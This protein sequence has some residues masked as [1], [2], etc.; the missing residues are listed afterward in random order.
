MEYA[1][2]LIIH[3]LLAIII[4]GGIL[5]GRMAVIP[6]A[7]RTNNPEFAYNFENAFSRGA[8]AALTIQFLVGFR[9]GMLQL[10]MAD[11]FTFE[12]SMSITL[13]AKLALFVVLFAWTI[14]GKR[15]FV[16]NA[17]TSDLSGL[18]KHY[19]VLTILALGLLF[20]GLNARLALV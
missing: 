11:W 13:V 7:G 1:V 3:A 16:K 8:H 15:M 14:I 18:K 4:I 12:T 19:N 6:F 9:L 2:L 5:V 10:G 17:D 20:F